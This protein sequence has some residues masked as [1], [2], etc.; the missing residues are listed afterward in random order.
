VPTYLDF[1]ELLRELRDRAGLTQGQ[2]A[3]RLKVSRPTFAQWEGGR[4]FPAKD[5]MQTLDDLFNGG[6]ALIAAFERARG[7]ARLR[8]VD[9]VE[10]APTPATRPLLQVFGDV[11]AAVMEQLCRDDKGRPLGWKHNLVPSPAPPVALSTAYVLK[12]LTVLGGLDP[13]TTGLVGRMFDLAIRD[14]EGRIVGWRASTAKMPRIETTTLVLEALQRLGADLDIDNSLRM[15]RDLYD[16]TARTRPVILTTALDAV[17]RLAPDSDLAAELTDNLLALR[18][19]FRGALLWPEKKVEDRVQAKLEPSMAHTARAVTVLRHAQ[20]NAVGDA[21]AV[22]EQWIAESSDLAGVS[23]S[24]SRDLGEGLREELTMHSF[25]SAHVVRALAGAR[26]PSH[27]RI[28]RALDYVW[29]RYDPDLHLWAWGNGDVP[30]WMLMDA[31]SALHD[32]ALALA[33][34]PSA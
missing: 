20:G 21:V 29:D 11:R 25:T 15:I 23:E 7:S 17:M 34:G 12:T 18:V 4:H 8:P 9:A 32:A 33:S 30:A 28:K 10:A 31:V 27:W 3:E 6:G 14:A 19:D 13:S 2:A 22:G 16:R 5:K 24:I 26:N 1:A